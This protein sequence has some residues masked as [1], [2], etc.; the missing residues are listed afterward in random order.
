[1][2]A[3]PV[4]WVLII[5]Y[6]LSAHRATYGRLDGNSYTKDYIQLYK[7][8]AFTETLQ[9]HFPDLFTGQGLVPLIYKWPA[10]T[11]QGALVLKSADRPHLKWDTA[12][13]APLAWKMSPTPNTASAET[14]PGNPLQ[15]DSETADS[16]F[17]SL[18]TSGVGQPYLM[19]IK[20]RGEVGTLHLRAYLKDPN[21]AYNWASIQLAPQ[22]IQALAEKTSPG[23]ALAWSTIDSGGSLPSTD[24]LDALQQ[25]ATH[26]SSASVLDGIDAD[27]GQALSVY[28]QSPAY[29]L[30]FDPTRNHDA[31]VQPIPLP[32]EIEASSEKIL[33]LLEVRFPLYQQG[34][35]VA[36]TLET[37]PEEVDAFRVQIEKKNYEVPDSHSTTK[38]RGSAQKVFADAVKK[39]YG[40]QCAITGIKTKSFLVASHIVP[41]SKD[42]SIRIDPSNGICLS[43][44]V[45]RAFEA[46]YLMIDDDHTVHIDWGKVSDD[47]ALQ[48]LLAPHDGQKLALPKVDT[49][50]KEYLQ[51]RRVLI[52]TNK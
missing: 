51:R 38:T 6:G 3:L 27:T 15:T 11:A 43:L 36:E 32:A 44:L 26:S 16:E 17:S 2:T 46:G 10:G 50:K 12:L 5:H 52:A 19:A 18:K 14:I 31:W 37:S 35:A 23:K 45:D 9:A 4:E 20:L 24:V 30:F 29:G 22:Q 39:N 28:L 47:K 48:S 49:P 7:S 42:Q 40:F 13:G 1:M 41:W 8:L 25:L 34:D 21:S 33:G